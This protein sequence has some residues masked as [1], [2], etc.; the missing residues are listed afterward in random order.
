[1]TRDLIEVN[2][3][4]DASNSSAATTLHAPKGL[5]DRGHAKN[6]NR[7]Q[8]FGSHRETWHCSFCFDMVAIMN[9]LLSAL[10][11]SRQDLVQAVMRALSLVAV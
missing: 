1:M 2:N 8:I 3:R 11:V 9:P 6:G 4:I 7:K 10:A 5:S